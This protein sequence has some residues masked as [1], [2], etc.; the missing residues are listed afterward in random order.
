MFIKYFQRT[1]NTFFMVDGSVVWLRCLARKI[2][3]CI[4]SI[5]LHG[6]GEEGVKGPNRYIDL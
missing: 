6:G 5:N 4:I 2:V 3:V 1:S